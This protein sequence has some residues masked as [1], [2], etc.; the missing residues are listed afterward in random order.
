M[1]RNI[2]RCWSLAMLLLAPYDAASF[3][4]LVD[5]PRGTTHSAAAS[6]LATA[7][8][9]KILTN[10]NKNHQQQNIYPNDF[11]QQTFDEKTPDQVYLLK[12]TKALQLRR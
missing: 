6:K 7:K 3:S 12:K 5:R 1:K 10:G 2:K 9:E 4:V 11:V 8:D